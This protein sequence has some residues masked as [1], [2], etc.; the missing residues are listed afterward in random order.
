MAELKRSLGLFDATA[1]AVGAIIGAG[2]FVISGVAAGLAGPAVILS[3]IIAGIVSSFTAY[4]YVRLASKFTEEGGPYVYAKNTISRFAGFITGWL[5]LFANIVA[6][7][8]VSLGLASYVTSL[9][10][11]LPIVPIAILS[12]LILVILN[13]VGIKQSSIFNAVLVALKLSALSLFIVIGFSHLNFSFYEPFSPNGIKGI[14]SSAALI[15]FAYTGF[16]RPATAAEEIKDPKHTIPRSIV[17]AL[18]L[19]SIVYI[20]V[21][22]VS[23]GLIPYQKIANSGSP[24]TDSIEYGIKIY[25]LEIFVSFAAIVAT[26]SVLLT[27]IIGVSRVSFAMARDNLL[28]KFFSK[29]HKRFSTPYLSILITGAVMAILPI[30]GSL[31][32][33]AN[34]TNFGS[35]LVY[36]IVNFTA[37]LLIAKDQNRM[38]R[39]LMVIP[40]LGL[41]SCIAL[42]YF[43]TP[44]SWIIGISWIAVGCVYYV[45]IKHRLN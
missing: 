18:V 32:Q 15:F 42:L 30:F 3:I 38:R 27:T 13:I 16:G 2:I 41:I 12:I 29:M 19:S 1:L 20:L 23:T 26:V 43:L 14:L 21:G 39:Y 17:L 24:I 9:L 4:S 33:T 45:V 7:A 36:A 40:A 5:W 11:T 8:T 22:I 6:G 35:L 37:I 44:I 34:V 25:W 31:K 10:P 28:P